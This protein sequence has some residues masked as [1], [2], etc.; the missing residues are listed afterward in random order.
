MPSAVLVTTAVMFDQRMRIMVPP[1]R[2]WRQQ[3]CTYSCARVCKI[4][5]VLS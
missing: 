2:C 4:K 1:M 3:L 5:D